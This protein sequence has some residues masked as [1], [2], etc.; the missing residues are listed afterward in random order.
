MFADDH[1]DTVWQCKYTQRSLSELK[2]KII[3]SLN[4]LNTSRRIA[5]WI[6]CVPVENSGAFLDWLREKISDDYPFISKWE[7]WDKQEIL[8]RLDRNP[9]VLEMFFYPIWKALESRFRTEEL[10]LV[11]Y[12]LDPEC[13]WRQPDPSILYFWQAEGSGSDLVIDIIVRS[14]GTIQSLIKAIGV[15]VF[16]VKRHLRGLPGAGLLYPQ[17]T[18]AISLGGGEAGNRI[19]KMEPPLV[20]EAGRHERFKVKLTDSGSAWTGYIRMILPYGKD[21]NLPLP[22]TFVRT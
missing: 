16:G 10:E 3:E 4:G 7:V 14:R 18:Y 6:L 2:P 17:H 11:Q 9:E 19:E 13:G 15:S 22:C 20:I 1:G 21:R 8:R 12:A 5:T